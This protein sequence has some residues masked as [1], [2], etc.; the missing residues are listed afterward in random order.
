MGSQKILGSKNI[1]L[2][3]TSLGYKKKTWISKYFGISKTVLP[4]LPMLTLLTLFTLLTLL[5]LLTLIT[6]LTLLIFLTICFTH[7]LFQ[8][9]IYPR[10][11]SKLQQVLHLK[12]RLNC[13]QL[14]HW[15][16]FWAKVLKNE[17]YKGRLPKKYL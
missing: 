14:K 11:A 9:K 4:I 5:T 6:L 16:T 3:R 15:V 2:S 12:F 17:C 1:L 7:H 10:K 13:L 8:T